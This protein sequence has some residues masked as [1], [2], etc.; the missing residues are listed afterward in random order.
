MREAE[1]K[2]YDAGKKIKGRK[3]HL[4]VDTLGILLVAWM[5][6]GDVQRREQPHCLTAPFQ[7]PSDKLLGK[8]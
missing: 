1:T 5:T 6:T 3:R 8:M 2:E 7:H 4:L